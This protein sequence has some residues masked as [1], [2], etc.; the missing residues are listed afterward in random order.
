MCYL[1]NAAPYFLSLPVFFISL[2]E[3]VEKERERERERETERERSGATV[4]FKSAI[5]FNGACALRKGR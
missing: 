4:F 2:I 5:L 3:F 1:I